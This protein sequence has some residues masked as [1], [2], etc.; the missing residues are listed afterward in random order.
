MKN[1]MRLHILFSPIILLVLLM[2]ATPSSPGLIPALAQADNTLVLRLSRDFG[3]SSGSGQIQGTF[4]MNV[5]GPSNL[6]RVDFFIDGKQIGE[7][8]A[9]P[10]NLQFNTGSYTLG[11]HSLS[12][13]G[14]T[15]D[16][17]ELHTPEVTVEFV[18]AETGMK[19]AG[20]IAF[21]I[22]VIAGV[23]ILL[24][25]LFPLLTGRGKRSQ[26][27][28][29]T[30]RQYGLRGGGI[31]PKCGRPFS[32]SLFS[33]NLL[34]SRFDRCPYCGRAGIF[35]TASISDLRKAEAAEL[36]AAKASQSVPEESE[37]E[38]LRKELD[39]SRYRGL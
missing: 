34:M 10:F 1:T 23:A 27:P 8:T 11:N 31:C 35:R 26:L 24:S 13:I 38:K 25:A 2:A 5:T 6:A 19:A 36:E 15:N 30:A 9:A 21:P 7:A 16:G 22:L 33:L 14:Y 20:R 12:A 37:D 28:L 4:S 3:F 17:Q 18:S 39:E 32:F 29:G